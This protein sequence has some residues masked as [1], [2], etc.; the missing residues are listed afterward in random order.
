[1][2]PR[3]DGRFLGEARCPEYEVGNSLAGNGR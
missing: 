2:L 1:M 3:V